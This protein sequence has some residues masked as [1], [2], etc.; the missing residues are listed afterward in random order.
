MQP[1]P[2]HYVIQ[3]SG[4]G[5]GPVTITAVGQALPGPASDVAIASLT[6]GKSVSFANIL[7]GYTT[8]APP[9]ST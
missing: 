3:T 9:V 7:A 6:V 8:A 5:D 2:H 4:T 1:Y